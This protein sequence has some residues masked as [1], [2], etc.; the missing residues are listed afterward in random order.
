MIGFQIKDMELRLQGGYYEFVHAD[1]LAVELHSA[2]TVGDIGVPTQA[3][4]LKV[5]EFDISIIITSSYTSILLVI[6]VA[7][8]NCPTVRLDLFTVGR[9]QTNDWRFLSG[10]PNSDTSI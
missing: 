5:K 9:F 6:R 10:V 2:Y 8:G 4:C 7:K 3:V 1:I